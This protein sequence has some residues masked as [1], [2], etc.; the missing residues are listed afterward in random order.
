MSWDDRFYMDGE[1]VELN[2]SMMG[3][4]E[5]EEFV[6][7]ETN[8]VLMK[9]DGAVM[10]VNALLRHMEKADNLEKKKKKNKQNRNFY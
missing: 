3:L 10:K 2:K 1:E 7:D 6:L 8:N 4:S 5:D 9:S